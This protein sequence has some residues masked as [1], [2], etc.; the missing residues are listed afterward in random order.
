MLLA[1][2]I[3]SILTERG[4]LSSFYEVATTT[5]QSKS[6]LLTNSN[7]NDNDYDSKLLS[8]MMTS[9]EK[10]PYIRKWGCDRME[11]PLLFIHIGKA[12]GGGVRAR[13]AASSL[14]YTKGDQWQESD[15]SYYPLTG[16]EK[17]RYCHGCPYRLHA[18]ILEKSFEKLVRCNAET[19]FGQAIG[20]PAPE[21]SILRDFPHGECLPD[22]RRA[23]WSLL[24]T[25]P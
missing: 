17:A 14:G 18:V 20:C 8:S 16:D 24:D 12:G 22:K 4:A 19:P 25:Y 21:S 9:T 15:N 5:L 6:S 13:L 11:T 23:I 2:C 10:A 3:G 7:E 1:F